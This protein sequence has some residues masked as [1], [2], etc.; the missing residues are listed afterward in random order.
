M[1]NLTFYD[2]EPS[3][4][5]FRQEVLQGLVQ[6]RKTIAPKF[7]YD[8]RGSQLFDQICTLPEYYPTRTE[9]SLLRQHGQEISEL[10][11]PHSLVIE[12]GSGSSQKIRLLLNALTAPSGYMP[13]DISRDHMLQSTCELASQYPALEMAAV[14]ADYTQPFDLPL[15]KTQPA[16]QRL[17]FFP[18]S[19]IGN[20]EPEAALRLLKQSASL[21]ERGGS[22]LLGVDL[23]KDPAILHAAYND[24]AGVTA[25]FNLNLLHR[26]NRELN[27]NFNL[28]TFRHY[29]FYNPA[30]G[31]VEMHLFSQQSQCVQIGQTSV[32]FR[33]GETIHTE[34]SYKYT[35]EE[36]Q[37]IAYL[38]GFTPIKTWI[39]DQQLFSVYY[40][41]VN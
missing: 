39:D 34:N 10:V 31:R 23:K 2:L 13:I 19:T 14:C 38:A 26:I 20:L 27:G 5:S 6:S 12:Y 25:A 24:A 8:R 32:S 41:T 15:L 3:A 35:V 11:G 17:L 18:G 1:D 16:K 33:A 4:S 37:E 7:F 29:A 28:E 22:L 40:L 36:F 30:K 9:T 21:L